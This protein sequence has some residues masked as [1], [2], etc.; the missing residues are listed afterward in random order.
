[1]EIN[2]KDFIII[3][4]FLIYILSVTIVSALKNNPNKLCKSGDIYC[5][6]RY[7]DK[8]Y[9]AFQNSVPTCYDE[10]YN[11]TGDPCTCV[12]FENQ[13]DSPMFYV[14]L[15]MFIF[16]L[17]LVIVY[18]FDSKPKPIENQLQFMFE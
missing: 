4:M 18:V 10:E 12:Q 11:N 15:C 7:G 16:I 17:I 1:M 6:H 3:L 9:C 5:K 13:D 2:T 14:Y 8:S